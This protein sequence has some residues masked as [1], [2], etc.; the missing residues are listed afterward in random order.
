MLMDFK[1]FFKK[2]KDGIKKPVKIFVG[3]GLITD[4][5]SNITIDVT[6]ILKH[7]GYFK[8]VSISGNIHHEIDL[9]ILP[10]R[11]GINKFGNSHYIIIKN[12]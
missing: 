1:G 9:T 3:S 8:Q 12:R 5:A 11:D 2:N 7:E 6:E 10:Y 4:K